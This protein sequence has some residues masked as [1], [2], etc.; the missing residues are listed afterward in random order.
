MDLLKFFPEKIAVTDKIIDVSGFSIEWKKKVVELAEKILNE[1]VKQNE[2]RFVVAFGGPSGSSKSTTAAV[3]EYL[4]KKHHLGSDVKV[5]AISQDGYHYEQ[6]YLKEH[7]DESGNPLIDHKGRYDTYDTDSL[8]TDLILFKEGNE[9][10]FP[11]YSRVSHNPSGFIEAKFEEP[12][13]LILE[14]LWLLYDKSPW[15]ELLSFYDLT[16]FFDTADERRKQNTISRH[17]AGNRTVE[18]AELFYNQSDRLNTEL[19]VSKVTP[20]NFDFLW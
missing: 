5:L 9:V 13:L 6:N 3:I 7:V 19:V 10:T 1:Y 11:M 8:Y 18:N 15:N 14:G 20:H 4:I 12:V 16:V 2:R 17:I